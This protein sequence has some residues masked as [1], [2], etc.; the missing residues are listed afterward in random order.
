[1]KLIIL[2]CGLLA[3]IQAVAAPRFVSA[4][5]ID[6]TRY[7]INGPALCATAL[8]TLA[9]LNKGSHYDPRVNHEGKVFKVSLSRVKA[10][11]VFICQ[12]QDELNNPAFIKKHFDFVRW[13]PDTEQTQSFKL[14]KPLIA[15]LPKDKILMTKY[16]VHRAK[17]SSHSTSVY[18]YPLYAL[19]RDEESLTLEEAETK[20]G[21]TRFQFGK[22]AILKGALATKNVPALAY[23]NRDD[24]EA[25]LMQGTVVADFGHQLKTF[26][27]HRNNN[28]PYD[29]AKNPYHQER[30]WYFKQVDGIK[31]Y[32]KDADHKITVNTEVTFAADIEQFGLGKLLMVQYQDKS[33]KIMTRAGIFAD[34]GGAFENN[35]YQVDFLAGSYAGKEAFYRATQ[36]LPNYVTAYFMILKNND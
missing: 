15:N 2:F 1:M 25:A 18:P 7:Q 24:L 34:T 6:S 36:H 20:P 16:Y 33:G 35:L 14:N 12:H 26:N 5:P 13:Y 4:A 9:Y 22:Q 3:S 19:P 10:T 17:A 31:G 21:L 28:I 11:L 29:K 32:G 8:E 27:V 30:Y 23:L